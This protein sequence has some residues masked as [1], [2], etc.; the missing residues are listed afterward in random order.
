MQIGPRE[1][2]PALAAQA[3]HGIAL[4]GEYLQRER[5]DLAAGMA[6]RAERPEAVPAK[7][8][9]NDLR[10]DAARGVAGADEQHVVELLRHVM[11]PLVTRLCPFASSSNRSTP[12]GSS[13]SS[14]TTA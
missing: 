9:Q 8:I 7:V 4:A 14:G 3:A 6:A 13:R 12:T 1:L 11:P 2:G 5:M 10:H